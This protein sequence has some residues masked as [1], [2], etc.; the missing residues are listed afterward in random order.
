MR[1]ARGWPRCDFTSLHVAGHLTIPTSDGAEVAI[2]LDDDAINLYAGKVNATFLV[3]EL[4][5]LRERD[6]FTYN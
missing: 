2:V 6:A 1:D 3:A 5:K 4:F